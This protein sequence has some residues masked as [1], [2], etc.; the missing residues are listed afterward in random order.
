MKT[1]RWNSLDVQLYSSS[2]FIIINPKLEKYRFSKC[3]SSHIARELKTIAVYLETVMVATIL[4]WILETLVLLPKT[5]KTYI[6]TIVQDIL[7]S[8]VT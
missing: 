2:P 4:D 1:D 3:N 8:T 5:N 6:T 7:A